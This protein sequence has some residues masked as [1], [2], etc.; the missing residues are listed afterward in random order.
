MSSNEL[1]LHSLEAVEGGMPVD[2]SVDTSADTSADILVGLDTSVGTVGGALVGGGR[3]VKEEKEKEKEKE[4]GGEVEEKE[5]GGEVEEHDKKEKGKNEKE[6][7][8]KGKRMSRVTTG[9][10]ATCFTVYL[11]MGIAGFSDFPTN[12]SANILDNYCITEHHDAYII[13][14]FIAI[15][16]TVSARSQY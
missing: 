1:E 7:E 11:L 15:T 14:A 8:K 16:I 13:G 10:V 2:T 3:K 6:K 4:M 12:T 9:A 5:V